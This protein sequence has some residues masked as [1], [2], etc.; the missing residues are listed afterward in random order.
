MKQKNGKDKNLNLSVTDLFGLLLSALE[1][2]RPNE[3]SSMDSAY[4]ITQQYV[5]QAADYYIGVCEW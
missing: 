5:T 2:E 3:V 4:K 1:E